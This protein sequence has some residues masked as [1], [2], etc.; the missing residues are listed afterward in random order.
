MFFPR[1]CV[2]QSMD[3]SEYDRARTATELYYK[4]RSMKRLER[5]QMYQNY[6]ST[7][8]GKQIFYLCI[9]DVDDGNRAFTTVC[10]ADDLEAIRI[11]EQALL[12]AHGYLIHDLT[13][14]VSNRLVQEEDGMKR[15][16]SLVVHSKEYQPK[17]GVVKLAVS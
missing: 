16:I 13:V 5:F 8:D 17:K 9:K 11:A 6:C 4:A 7:D 14:G 2:T 12:A 10:A 15:E 3:P 1:S